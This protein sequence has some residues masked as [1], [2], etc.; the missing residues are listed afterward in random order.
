MR[1]CHY[2]NYVSSSLVST[3]RAL[4]RER[5]THMYAKEVSIQAQSMFDEIVMIFE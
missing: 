2:A 3:T 1:A 4:A 5:N